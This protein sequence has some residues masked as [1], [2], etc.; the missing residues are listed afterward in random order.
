[1][2]HRWVAL[3]R[4][5]KEE[6][7]SGRYLLS[8]QQ[9]QQLGYGAAGRAS[10]VGP[11]HGEACGQAATDEQGRQYWATG[12]DTWHKAAMGPER[13]DGGGGAQPDGG[14]AYL[15]DVESLVEDVT[16]LVGEWQTEATH[17]AVAAAEHAAADDTDEGG[18]SSVRSRYSSTIP[19]S[20]SRCCQFLK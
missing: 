16:G 5:Y 19:G 4:G 9:E 18:F 20:L 15:D 10:G 8:E 11:V 6:R 13:A 1:M 7:G 12:N 17:A 14:S 2:L 3:L